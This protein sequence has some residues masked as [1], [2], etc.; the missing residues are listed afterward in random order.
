MLVGRE[1][2]NA[3]RDPACTLPLQVAVQAHQVA[4]ELRRLANVSLVYM[5]H[6]VAVI[7]SQNTEVH[8]DINRR[9]KH[10]TERMQGS[11]CKALLTSPADEGHHEENYS[12]AKL[13]SHDRAQKGVLKE[14]RL[15]VLNVAAGAGTGKVQ[16]HAS[17]TAPAL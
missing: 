11:F 9:F 15:H 17:I 4:R 13:V 5:A 3:P 10:V 7:P 16:R 6:P 1:D 14:Q 8:A 2:A 12:K